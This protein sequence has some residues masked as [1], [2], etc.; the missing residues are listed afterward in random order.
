MA[1]GV[2]VL[3]RHEGLTLRPYRPGD[4]EGIRALFK[5]AYGK[6][7]SPAYWRWKF[8]DNPAGQQIM[9]AVT[10]TGEVV[11]QYAGVPA[12]AAKGS[13]SYL[14]SQA[15][16][17][18]VDPRFR[19]G[20]KNP[21]LQVTLVRRFY[22]AYMGPDAGAMAYGFPVPVYS[23]LLVRTG[24]C[25]VLH[26]V[27][28]LERELTGDARDPG[29]RLAAL[30]YRIEQVSR[31]PAAVDGLWRRCQQELPLAIIRDARYL[32]W[33]YADCPEATY[34]MLLA[35]DRWTGQIAGTAVLRLGFEGRPVALLVDWLVPARGRSLTEALLQHCHALAVASGQSRSE[36]WIPDYSP[37]VQL[38]KAH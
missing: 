11:G 17:S 18:M 16:E 21:G 26:R 34:T 27:V 13:R 6:E 29:R 7:R 25:T 32:N 10:G 19:R 31:F 2:A 20:L 14:L 1:E 35:T 15:V 3:A 37:Q 4:E 8:C 23:R 9:L 38:L 36:A 28:Q 24:V 30:R 33:R 12:L 5:M 22:E